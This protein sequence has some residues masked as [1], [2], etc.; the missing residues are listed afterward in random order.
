M[1]GRNRQAAR[2]G[3]QSVRGEHINLDTAASEDVADA[4][5]R[6]LV[7]LKPLP[8]QCARQALRPVSISRIRE[9]VGI[10]AYARDDAAAFGRVKLHHACADERPTLDDLGK[11]EQCEPH[12]ALAWVSGA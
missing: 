6:W 11:V 4:E 1:S 10:D 8:R 12:I 7:Q 2:D 9:S 3:V 5:S